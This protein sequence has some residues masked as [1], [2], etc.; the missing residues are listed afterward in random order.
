VVKLLLKVNA[1][2]FVYFTKKDDI[3]TINKVM[4][5]ITKN[6]ST[7]RVKIVTLTEKDEIV[8]QNF[9]DDIDVLDRAYPEIHFDFIQEYGKF[10]PET[11]MDLSKKWKIPTNFMFIGSPGDKF[12]YPLEELGELR[13]II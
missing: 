6:E 2:E 10:N 11:I 8:P 5:Y 3:A 1:Q 9:I 13:L 7:R 12:P 4:Q